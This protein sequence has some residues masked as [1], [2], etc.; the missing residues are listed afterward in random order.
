[1]IFE[2]VPSGP[3][4]TNAFLIG[5]PETKIGYIVDPAPGS[6]DKLL[7]LAKGYGLTIKAIYLTHSHW[8]HF[9]DAASIVRELGVQVYAH[10]LAEENLVKP[11]SDGLPMIP[12]RDRTTGANSPIEAVSVDGYLSDGDRIEMG[13]ISFSVIHVPGHSPGCVAFYFPNEKLLISGD[14]LFEGSHGNVSFPT[15]DPDRMQNSLLRLM[16]LDDDVRVFPGHMADTT[17]GQERRWICP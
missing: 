8:D 10:K 15:S 7:E 14:A 3:I 16:E 6:K 5:C 17:I 12:L 2:C 1:M 9:A 13:N 11:G 4:L